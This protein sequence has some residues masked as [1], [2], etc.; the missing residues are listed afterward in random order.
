VIEKKGKRFFFLK[1]VILQFFKLT[2]LTS[3]SSVQNKIKNMKDFFL[4]RKWRGVFLT[5]KRDE[6]SYYNKLEVK[7]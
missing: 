4:Q 5:E 3:F 2:I 7:I 6:N 1:K